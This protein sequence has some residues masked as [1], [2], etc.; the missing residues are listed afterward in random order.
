[1]ENC[2]FSRKLIVHLF[3]LH[4]IGMLKNIKIEKLGYLFMNIGLC[5]T[6][7]VVRIKVLNNDIHS[8]YRSGIHLLGISPLCLA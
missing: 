3:G 6:S 7:L 4:G 5:S 1:M 2:D 8:I